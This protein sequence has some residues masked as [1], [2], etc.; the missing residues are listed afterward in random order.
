MSYIHSAE[1]RSRIAALWNADRSGTQ[2]AEELGPPWTR[3]KVIGLVNRMRRDGMA[4][5]GRQKKWDASPPRPYVR[6]ERPRLC[7]WQGC[8]CA[9]ERGSYCM[10]HAERVYQ[11]RSNGNGQA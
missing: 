4:I 10:P 1:I 2:I 9:R 5:R 8:R 7:Q 11:P 6:L 3:C